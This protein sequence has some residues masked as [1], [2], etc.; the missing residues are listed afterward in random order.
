MS[1]KSEE[2]KLYGK[3]NII[4]SKRDHRWRCNTQNKSS[5]CGGKAKQN[6]KR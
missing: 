4:I 2:E 5:F 3:K 1:S 6:I